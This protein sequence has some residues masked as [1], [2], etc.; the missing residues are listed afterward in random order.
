MKL[1]RFI[2]NR[3][4]DYRTLHKKTINKTR[5]LS[6]L[7]SPIIVFII[8]LILFSS[9]I[10][11]SSIYILDESKNA[12]C[13]WEMLTYDH[14]ITPTFNGEL[15]TDKPPL[16]YYFMMIGYKLFGKSAFGARIFSSIFG[17]IFMLIFFRFLSRNSS[18]QHAWWTMIVLWSSIHFVLE[19]HL[20]VPDPYL[21]TCIGL[22]LIYFFEAIEKQIFTSATLMYIFVALGILA[23]GPI[24]ILLP[25]FIMLTYLLI[26][27]QF[28]WKIIK[29]L[30]PLYGVI[31]VAT[32]AIP[33]YYMVYRETNG[34]WLNE[35]FFNHN[36][37][38]FESTKEGHGGFVL[39]T[40]LYYFMGFVPYVFFI[41]PFI[42]YLKNAQKNKL[43]LFSVITTI[44]F[45][46]FFSISSTK[47]PNY[48]MPAYPFTAFLLGS[49]IVDAILQDKDKNYRLNFTGIF[50]FTILLI[51][52][53]GVGIYYDSNLEGLY[54][55]LVLLKLLPFGSFMAIRFASKHQLQNSMITLALSFSITGIFIMTLFFPSI[56][57]R[58]P[59]IQSKNVITG[60]NRVAYYHNINPAYI[61]QYDIIQKL[62]TQEEVYQFLSNPKNI[63]LT[64][65]KGVKELEENTSLQVKFQCTDLFDTRK[66]RI[67]FHNP[68]ISHNEEK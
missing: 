2:M 48:A 41:I 24:G 68:V 11:R 67:V 54:K 7:T 43:L 49:F 19:F 52:G 39:L 12:Q 58:N 33:W 1:K 6:F 16:H 10:R 53:V 57:K 62:T 23:K 63:L 27:K 44:C 15:R 40:L 46:L 60:A 42:K 8:S 64:T 61:F 31:I 25:G 17:S 22:S 38:R 29:K 55:L 45:I 65:E 13:A 18:K 36:I 37:G 59:I 30:Y 66:T 21:I 4:S 50:I 51:I 56:D 28:K 26:T 32:I 47:L 20:A 9:G 14:L 3:L 34:V 5:N 35:F